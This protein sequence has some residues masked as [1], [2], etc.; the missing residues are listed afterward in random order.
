MSK[1]HRHLSRRTMGFVL[2]RGGDSGMMELTANRT[3]SAVY[4][5][6]KT[7]IID[8]ALSNAVNS[9]IRKIAIATEDKAY[10]LIRHCQRGWGHFRAER[11][12][13]LAIFPASEGRTGRSYSGTAGAVAQ[14][15]DMIDAGGIDLILVLAG[16]H[17]YKMDYEVMLHQHV[18]TSADVTVG[19]LD[20]RWFRV[21]E[22]GI[23]LITAEMIAQRV[24]VDR[25]DRIVDFDEKPDDPAPSA[26]DPEHALVSMEIYVFAWPFLR[27]Q[28]KKDG[29]DTDS[30]HDFGC[31]L[32]P[33]I[34]RSGKAVAHRFSESVFA[35][36]PRRP[37]T[38][39]TSA[40][41]TRIGG[42]ISSSPTSP[43]N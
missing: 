13:Y 8:F 9:G 39:V 27:D 11:N 6:G 23:T 24:T 4:F 10:S 38:G 21:T 36:R 1:R 20:A 29:E 43:P 31:D 40:R 25:H 12:E 2:A 41:S 28:L 19:C 17:I 26:D 35:S 15:I 3:K 18:E 37:S 5:A 32:I 33:N 7:R 34:V 16:D 14:N 30:G 22:G 42:P